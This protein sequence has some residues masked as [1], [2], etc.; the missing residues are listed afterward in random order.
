ME[1]S[2]CGTRDHRRNTSTTEPSS[3]RTGVVVLDGDWLKIVQ[4]LGLSCRESQ[5]SRGLLSGHTEAE[6]AHR[7]GIAPRTVHA[8]LERLYRKLV[9][10][11][12]CELILCLFSAYIREEQERRR[13]ADAPSQAAVQ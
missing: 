6:I 11:S 9:V 13:E 5:I 12:R 7:L 4:Q 1:P 3:S 2:L 10:H 8:H